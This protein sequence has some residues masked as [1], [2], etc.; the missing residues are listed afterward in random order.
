MFNDL[1]FLMLEDLS[2]VVN[3]V[4]LYLQLNGLINN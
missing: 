3:M 4:W 1:F 2:K